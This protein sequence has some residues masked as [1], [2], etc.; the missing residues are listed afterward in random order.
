[1]VGINGGGE[2]LGGFRRREMGIKTIFFHTT[3]NNQLGYGPQQ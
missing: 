3:N 2:Q 1:L